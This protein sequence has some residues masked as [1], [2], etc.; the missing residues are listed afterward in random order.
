M[1]TEERQ[2]FYD[3]IITT[4]AEIEAMDEEDQE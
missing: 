3:W 4:L 2:T 1:K